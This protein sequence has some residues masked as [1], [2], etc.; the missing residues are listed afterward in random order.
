[1]LLVARRACL[2]GYTETVGQL[3]KSSIAASAPRTHSASAGHE[4]RP[5]YDRGDPVIWNC[6]APPLS[7]AQ[8]CR[9][10]KA[11]VNNDARQWY[12]RPPRVE[13][14]RLGASLPGAR[15]DDSKHPTIPDAVLSNA[16]DP[17]RTW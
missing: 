10:L 15:V 6:T 17:E 16:H 7:E 4:M 14:A 9:G 2:G 1:M 5:L 13:Y 8:P 11:A 3:V 12:V